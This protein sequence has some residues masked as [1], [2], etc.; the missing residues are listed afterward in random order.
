M[1]KAVDNAG[2]ESENFA[3]CTVNLGDP[4]ED[5]VLL[6]ID[7]SENNWNAV[8]T[9]GNIFSD[10]FIHSK[11]SGTHYSAQDAPYWEKPQA[12]F[13]NN[14]GF[15][16]FTVEATINCP[17]AGNFYLLYEIDGAA[18]ITYC[19]NGKDSIYKPY[20]TK[21]RVNAGDVINV[22]FK[23]PGGASETI[24]KKLV[25]VI[26]VPDR[27]EHFE[28]LEVPEAGLTLPI[29]T[30]HYAT[31]AVHIDSIRG[32]AAQQGVYMPEIVSRT[33]CL[34]KIYKL[35]LVDGNWQQDYVDAIVDITWQGYSDER[36]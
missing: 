22:R 23:T 15:K 2:Q 10:G 1:I 11:Q 32:D 18:D 12:N 13:W 35:E 5:N 20:A 4:L 3:H 34:I 16:N 6:K 19:V 33:P 17:A 27:E 31:T 36:M 9:D 26:D 7:L 21:F 8:V 25:A 14:E 24:L 28:N 30:P 29:K